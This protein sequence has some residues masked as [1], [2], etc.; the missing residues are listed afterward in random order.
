MMWNCEN[1]VPWLLGIKVSTASTLEEVLGSR[2]FDKQ[3]VCSHEQSIVLGEVFT[4][5]SKLF[6]QMN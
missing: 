6:V 4:Q 2:L 1:N 5:M 3:A